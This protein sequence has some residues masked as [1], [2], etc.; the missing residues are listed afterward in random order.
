VSRPKLRLSGAR[1]RILALVGLAAALAAAGCAPAP[2]PER[3]VLVV[4]DTL[5]RDHLGCYGGSIPTPNIDALAASGQLFTN[6]VASFHQTTMSM[7][8]LFTG[9]TPSLESGDPARPLAWNGRTWCGMARFAPPQASRRACLPPEV[10]N[11]GEELRRAGYWTIG[12]ASN[13]FLFRPAGFARGFDDWSEVGGLRKPSGPLGRDE[14]HT[15]FGARNGPRVNS[16]VAAA[17]DRRRADRFFLYVHYMDVHDFG[18]GRSYPQGVRDADAAVGDLQRLLA[19]RGLLEHS[20]VVLTADHGE[21]L[22]E[23][24]P[25]EGTPSHRGNPSFEHLL[26]IPL[27]V[28]PA[29]FGDPDGLVR[30]EDLFRML[31]ELAGL[32]AA[33]ASELGGDEVFL[34]E[35]RWRTLR[36][37]RWKSMWPRENGDALLFDLAADPGERAN[38]ADAHAD[39]LAEHRRRMEELSLRLAAR[40][41]PAEDL[42]ADDRE[43]LR[44]LGYLE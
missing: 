11:L 31:R 16:A 4:I 34:T 3:I 38:A 41:R 7:G 33:A 29:R 37:G 25:V 27:L 23:E 1:A 32:D 43:R 30:S 19:E 2:P 5:R 14:R 20:V 18:M 35:Q 40:T 24:H 44:V 13:Q 39:V 21:R 36:Q 9:R 42:S 6:A 28:A 26:R 22:R 12:V 15:W 17:L 8:A 10:P